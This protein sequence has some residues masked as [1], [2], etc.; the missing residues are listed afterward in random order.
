MV[1]L[2]GRILNRGEDVVAFQEG[3]ILQ[4]F[5]EGSAGTEQFQHIAHAESFAANARTTAALAGLDG[6]ALKQFRLHAPFS[7]P[8]LPI[9]NKLE[10][11]APLDWADRRLGA[12]PIADLPSP[13]LA[14]LRE[15]LY[16]HHRQPSDATPSAQALRHISLVLREAKIRPACERATAGEQLP[17][18]RH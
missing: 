6:D 1:R 18:H 11:L 10:T 13:S 5:V 2:P 16:H 9:V 14:L 3:I 12:G 4:D 17:R 7:L 8:H 15:L